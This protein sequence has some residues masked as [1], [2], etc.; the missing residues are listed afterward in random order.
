RSVRAE[1]GWDLVPPPELPRN[2][3]GLDL[4]HPIEKRVL[5]LARHKACSPLFD[6]R[7]GRRGEHARVAIP[8]VG[9]PGFDYHTRA[10]VMRYCKRVI[11]DLFEKAGSCE[12][13]DY[14]FSCFKPVETA[15][16]CRCRI[17]QPRIL[18]ED[19]DE[20]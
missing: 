20:R 15:I 5:P 10:V 18:V 7:Q 11:F 4:S 1:P 3:P 17:G 8:L 12:V 6:R 19:V 2:A 14:L 16:G 9:E 13:C